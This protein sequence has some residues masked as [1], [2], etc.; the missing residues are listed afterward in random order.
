MKHVAATCTVT[1]NVIITEIV[2]AKT[3]QSSLLRGRGKMSKRVTSAK[4]SSPSSANLFDERRISEK[5]IIPSSSELRAISL[6][7][8]YERAKRLSPTT[9]SDV[10]SEATWLLASQK[11]TGRRSLERLTSV[12]WT[13][14]R[15]GCTCGSKSTIT[16][17][18]CRLTIRS[19]ATT[20]S[21]SA[22]A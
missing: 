2:A 7:S 3:G 21:T 1:I 6:A 22:P 17:I 12:S 16:F 20:S 18:F 14:G 8:L 9:S 13:S 4:P 15:D 5:K 19:H 11:A 10:A